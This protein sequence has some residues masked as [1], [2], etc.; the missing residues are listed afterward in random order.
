MGLEK[1]YL[2]NLSKL[3]T[4]LE[5]EVPAKQFNMAYFLRNKKEA[6]NPDYPNDINPN[7]VINECGTTG[8][9]LGW[10]SSLFFKESR[11]FD[12]WNMF[13]EAMFGISFGD[14]HHEFYDVAAYMFDGEWS[15]VK[16]QRTKTAT[17]R[18]IR[19]VVKQKG[20][21]T[22]K[23]KNLMNKYRIG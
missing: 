9:A 1:K 11:Q 7:Q 8:C 12:S 17:V 15:E 23:Q 2:K 19:D 4:F 3:A 21:L 14:R 13:G 18:R 16:Y 6:K 5:R 10:A 20:K 22:A